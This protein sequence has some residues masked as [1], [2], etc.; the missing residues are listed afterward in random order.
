M[1]IPTFPAKLQKNRFEVKD[2]SAKGDCLYESVRDCLKHYSRTVQR[3]TEPSQEDLRR[4]VCFFYR[5][6]FPLVEKDEDGMATDDQGTY[7]FSPRIEKFKR[8][9]GIPDHLWNLFLNFCTRDEMIDNEPLS[10][11]GKTVKELR[12][13]A[14]EN[15]I[16]TFGSKKPSEL[17]FYIESSGLS[18]N[19]FHFENVCK[20]LKYSGLADVCALSMVCHV[21]IIVYSNHS[22]EL[23]MVAWNR[24]DCPTIYI[25]FLDFGHFTALLPK[26]S[27]KAHDVIT[28][29]LIEIEDSDKEKEAR[30]Q[31]LQPSQSSD[32]QDNLESFDF[33]E[34]VRRS[35]EQPQMRHTSKKTNKNLDSLLQEAIRQSREDVATARTLKKKKNKKNSESSIDESDELRDAIRMSK[36]IYG[37]RTRRLR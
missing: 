15:G 20:P 13:L 10:L 24:H 19:V 29:E 14:Q 34:G 37:G 32:K 31:S 18:N 16:D 1:E 4:K 6:L 22:N 26:D 11:D 3:I 5:G 12:A 7:I 27:P 23:V 28:S 9:Y 33:Q 21:N 8:D 30:R 2:N 35:L 25:N 36:L 17:K